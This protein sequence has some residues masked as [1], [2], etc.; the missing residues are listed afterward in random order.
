MNHIFVYISYR[1]IRI[2]KL[3]ISRN[4]FLIDIV[5]VFIQALVLSLMAL[6][7]SLAPLPRRVQMLPSNSSVFFDTTSCSVPNLL[8]NSLVFSLASRK[9][10]STLSCE[11]GT[12]T[13]LYIAFCHLNVTQVRRHGIERI[14]TCS[15]AVSGYLAF[16]S[17][18]TSL[19]LSVI[20]LT[21]PSNLPEFFW[22]Y[23]MHDGN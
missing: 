23:G 16:S 20:S 12:C 6:V 19:N 2:R 8:L 15:L 14:L 21:T 17:L 11:Q 18:A 9:P 4:S 5:R 22:A 10:F 7:I 13:Q 3:R 1:F